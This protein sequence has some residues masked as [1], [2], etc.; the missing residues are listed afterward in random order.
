[1]PSHQARHPLPAGPVASRQLSQVPIFGRRQRLGS[2][3]SCY[4]LVSCSPSVSNLHLIAVTG[5]T[6]SP[7]TFDSRPLPS[8]TSR[9]YLTPSRSTPPTHL[10]RCGLTE[11]YMPNRRCR[12]WRH[13]S[14]MLD[15]LE[16]TLTSQFGRAGLEVPTLVPRLDKQCPLPLWVASGAASLQCCHRALP[17]SNPR[18]Y[19][20]TKPFLWS[21]VMPF[22]GCE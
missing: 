3:R 13:G 22:R 6:T 17:T 19:R 10:P 8:T 5:M 15:S 12:P 9:P 21:G 18:Q 11:R 14:G 2:R 7:L 16:P 1:M 20:I 4:P